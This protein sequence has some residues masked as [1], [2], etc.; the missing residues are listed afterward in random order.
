MKDVAWLAAR[1]RHACTDCAAVVVEKCM[2]TI[3]APPPPLS[4]PW[5]KDEEMVEVG[6]PL[7]HISGLAVLGV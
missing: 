6:Y 4:H 7:V 3:D 2:S 1:Q 5:I